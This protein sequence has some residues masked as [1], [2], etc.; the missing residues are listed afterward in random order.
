MTEDQE[1]FD[2]AALEVAGTI[3]ATD[4]NAMESPGTVARQAA[5]IA[6]ALLEERRAFANEQPK[7]YP[8]P[9]G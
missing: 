6:R 3:I 1:F 7:G 5:A 2:R 9:N 4:P 8:G